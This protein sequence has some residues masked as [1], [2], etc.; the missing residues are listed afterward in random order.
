MPLCIY[1]KEW[2]KVPYGMDLGRQYRRGRIACAA[3]GAVC[4]R[5]LGLSAP[6]LLQ[7]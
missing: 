5:R 3:A 6:G 7:I 4:R 1:R 2:H